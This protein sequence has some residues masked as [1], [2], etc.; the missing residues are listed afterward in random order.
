MT[1]LISA[2]F[3][4]SALLFGGAYAQTAREQTASDP[5]TVLSVR[6]HMM[7]GNPIGGVIDNTVPQPQEYIYDV[8]IRQN[9]DVYVARYESPTKQMPATFALNHTVKIRLDRHLMLFSA[10]ENGQTVTT[11]IL[12]HERASGCATHD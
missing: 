10:P 2:A 7:P 4:V 8:E 12:S 1:R 9:C 5:A 11:A 3:L 6:S